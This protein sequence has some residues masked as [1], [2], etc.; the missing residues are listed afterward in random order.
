MEK[1]ELKEPEPLTEEFIDNNYWKVTD[2]K[3]D[4]FDVDALLAELES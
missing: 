1:V 4:E 3:P 2:T